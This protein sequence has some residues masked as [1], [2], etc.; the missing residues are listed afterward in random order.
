MISSKHDNE[1]ELFCE[2]NYFCFKPLKFTFKVSGMKMRKVSNFYRNRILPMLFWGDIIFLTRVWIT[3]L[4]SLALYQAL[5]FQQKFVWIQV[6]ALFYTINFQPIFTAPYPLLALASIPIPSSRL[7]PPPWFHFF[8]SHTS[9]LTPHT[10]YIPSIY[11][12]R[13]LPQHSKPTRIHNNIISK[14]ISR[15]HYDKET[16]AFRWDS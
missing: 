8:Q 5:C 16:S 15:H 2:M 4:V 7:V 14:F 12:V 9:Q 10:T 11:G 3:V 6:S 13:M 1:D